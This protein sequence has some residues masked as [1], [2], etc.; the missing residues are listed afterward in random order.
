MLMLP[1]RVVQ[2][3]RS[4]AQGGVPK[5]DLLRSLNAQPV[6]WCCTQKPCIHMHKATI[7]SD[8]MLHTKAAHQNAL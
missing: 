7:Q 6:T 4:W 3:Q 2:L 5:E 1:A 8:L